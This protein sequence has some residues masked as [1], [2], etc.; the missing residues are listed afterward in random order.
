MFSNELAAK[1]YNTFE[2][3]TK[4]IKIIDTDHAH[5][6]DKRK[7]SA[8]HKATILAGGTLLFSI[9]TPSTGYIHYRPS[10]IYP[11]ADKVDIAL[12]EGA[13]INVAGTAIVPTNRNRTGTIPTSTVELKHGTTFTADGTLLPGLSVFLPG[14]TGVG[15]VRNGSEIGADEEILLKPDTVYRLLI[16]NGS[17]GSNIIGFNFGWYEED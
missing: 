7:Y 6:H 4:N 2:S 3:I 14:S 16:T 8:F 15:T 12:Y 13:T 9:K 10:K 1:F 11:S 5:I 17:S